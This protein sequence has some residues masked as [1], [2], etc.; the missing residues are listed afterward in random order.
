MAAPTA[1]PLEA[2][3]TGGTNRRGPFLSEL[4]VITGVT[5]VATDTVAIT[6]RYIKTP[7]GAIGPVGFSVSGQV[8]T[9]QLLTDIGTQTL[10][11]EIVGRP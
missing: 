8:I 4:Y 7:V 10:L 11:V 5:S 6:P 2:K 1:A 3:G 9:L